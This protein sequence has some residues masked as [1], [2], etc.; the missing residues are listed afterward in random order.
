MY[1]P[2]PMV[3]KNDYLETKCLFPFEPVIQRVFQ[4]FLK[5]HLRQELDLREAYISTNPHFSCF[6]YHKFKNCVRL[7][8][9]QNT[10]ILT[11]MKHTE[12]EKHCL[13]HNKA[14]QS[15]IHGSSEDEQQPGLKTT[16]H[17]FRSCISKFFSVVRRRVVSAFNKTSDP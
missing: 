17:K 13:G 12:V 4:I 6:L 11:I 8:L 15:F 9:P 16:D 5:W 10:R 2:E 1:L 7:Y 3:R 14:K